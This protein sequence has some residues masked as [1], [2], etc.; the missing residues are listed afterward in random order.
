MS[1]LDELRTR[2]PWPD[3]RPDV[4]EDWT[5]WFYADNRHLLRQL[6]TDQTKV[7]VELGSL[8]GLS[9]RFLAET[10]PNATII[11]IDHW[12]GS[13]EHQGREGWDQRLRE[14]YPRFLRNLWPWRDRVIPMR[15]TTLAGMQEI[16][17]LKIAPELLYV[18][19]AHDTKSVQDDVSA[20]LSLFA[21]ADIVGDDWL[22]APV[23]LGVVLASLPCKFLR[24][25]GD[26]AW[27]LPVEG[28]P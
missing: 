23:R 3:K 20:A 6:L 24:V 14:L 16:V 27:H 21:E 12:K 7:V 1:G 11:C 9:S 28:R 17:D 19:A 15:T 22:H 26:G 18:D 10:A 13:A 2:Y 25:C 5:G 8:C 4:V